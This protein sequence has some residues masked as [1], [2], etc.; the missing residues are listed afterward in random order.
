MILG[1]DVSMPCTLVGLVSMGVSEIKELDAKVVE[2]PYVGKELVPL[3]TN[4]MVVE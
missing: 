3:E 2:V 1:D 4:T